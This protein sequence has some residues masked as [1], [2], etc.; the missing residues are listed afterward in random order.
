MAVDHP[1]GTEIGITESNDI[2]MYDV[3]SVVSSEYAN[4]N[5]IYN[6]TNSIQYDGNGKKV[7]TGTETDSIFAYYSSG[8]QLKSLKYLKS[9]Y[10]VNNL[11]ST[12]DSFALFGE[13]GG[14][15]DRLWAKCPVAD[16][17]INTAGETY[18]RQIARRESYS[19]VIIPFA[20]IND[21][22]ASDV[23]I[24][25]NS[26]FALTYFSVVPIM[27]SG[28]YVNDLE[29]VEA[30]HSIQGDVI[31]LLNFEDNYYSELDSNGYITLKFNDISTVAEGFVRDYVL[32]TKGR[33]LTT[34]S[35]YEKLPQSTD[36]NLCPDGFKL[37]TNFPNPFNPAT[38]IK[39]DLPKD[40]KV[41]IRIYDLLGR[42]VATLL[43]N[44]F[45]YA[46]RYELTWNASNY[47]TGVY[48][49]RIEAGEF[50]S[51]KKMVLIK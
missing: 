42:E 27:Y 28:F 5:G 32:E 15:S 11:G 29:L 9:K 14:N 47:A 7:V 8:E 30:N 1:V 40:V 12:I 51:T 17:V 22:C 39:Y 19:D 43:N 41:T 37:Y 10:S 2:I 13:I 6:I 31:S 26:D 48:I 45:K 20:G 46:G 18:Y 49:Y 23:N 50:V 3:N 36:Q 21:E 34:L 4:L 38:L 33:Y 35:E 24:N 25:W 44:E 16:L